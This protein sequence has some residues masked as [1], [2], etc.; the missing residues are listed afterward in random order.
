MAETK[1]R[2]RVEPPRFEELLAR[3]ESLPGVELAAVTTAGEIPPG[4]FHATNSFAIEGRNQPLGGPRPIARY[5]VVSPGYFAIMGIPLLQGRLLTDLDGEN[6]APVAVVNRALVRRYFDGENPIGK[7]IRTGPN[8]Q[9]WRTIAGVVGDVKTSGLTVAAEPA[10]YLPYRQAGA[11]ADVGVVMRSSLDAGIVAAELRKTVAS[12]DRNQPIATVQA[13]SDRLS[14]SVSGPRFT[15]VL[16]FVFAGLA[17]VLG[18]IGVYGVMG[19][20]VRW[21]LR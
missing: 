19:C 10:I 20:R 21:Q 8:D 11:F 13:M 6:A 14:E 9:P 3:A 2:H 5:P 1:T 16:L 12:L 18:L 7:R 4:D 17:A 15:T